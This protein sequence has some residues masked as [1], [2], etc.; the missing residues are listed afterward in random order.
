[1][2]DFVFL[3]FLFLQRVRC[4]GHETVSGEL[5]PHIDTLQLCNLLVIVPSA[6]FAYSRS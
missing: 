2:R 1:M 6:W 4:N 5:V 3:Y